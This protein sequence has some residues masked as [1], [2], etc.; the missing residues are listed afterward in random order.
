MYN[1]FFFLFSSSLRFIGRGFVKFC[2]LSFLFVLVITLS[3]GFCTSY[4]FFG[5]EF[6]GSIPS[7]VAHS[8]HVFQFFLY[9]SYPRSSTQGGRGFVVI[10]GD[11]EKGIRR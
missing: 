3:S 6:V 5:G 1:V 9:V 4:G 10:V 2:I 7:N 8:L 11:K